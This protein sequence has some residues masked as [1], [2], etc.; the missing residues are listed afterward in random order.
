MGGSH[1][2]A[3]AARLGTVIACTLEAMDTVQSILRAHA[4][5][6]QWSR[7]SS[8]PQALGALVACC[9]SNLA[10]A[11]AAGLAHALASVAEDAAVH[12]VI[13]IGHDLPSPQRVQLSDALR[14]VRASTFAVLAALSADYE[15]EGTARP[16]HEC[17][18][19][20]VSLDDALEVGLSAMAKTAQA[21]CTGVHTDAHDHAATLLRWVLSTA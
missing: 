11:L 12:A 1:G 5:I 16:R 9:T 3:H 2:A 21:L 8:D 17:T 20:R 7:A 15:N 6:Q 19:S 4:V 14:A 18:D 10:A 13:A